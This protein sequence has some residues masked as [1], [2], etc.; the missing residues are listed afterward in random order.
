MVSH[1][2]VLRWASL[3]TRTNVSSTLLILAVAS[4]LPQILLIQRKQ[5]THGV[6]PLCILWNLIHATEQFTI[7]VYA[8]YTAYEP[9]GTVLLHSP[10]SQGDRFNL[11]HC[12]AITALFL[13]L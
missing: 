1:V 8:L 6:S 4:F 9:D 2:R 13:A 12:A 3:E 10:L 7:F 11:W 5:S